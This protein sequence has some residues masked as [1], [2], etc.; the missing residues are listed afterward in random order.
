MAPSWPNTTPQWRHPGLTPLHSV[1]NNPN[2]SDLTIILKDGREVK[3]HK[4]ILCTSNLWFKKA[5][6]VDSQFAV[7]RITQ[8]FQ[9]VSLIKIPTVGSYSASARAQA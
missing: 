9:I 1:Y 4:N 2:Y 6:G 5:C 8:L 3:V 7:R